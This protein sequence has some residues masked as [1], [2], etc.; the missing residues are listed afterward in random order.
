[1]TKEEINK[2]LTKAM[3]IETQKTQY[4]IVDGYGG[5]GYNC[6]SDTRAEAQRKL[7]D[8]GAYAEIVKVV[9]NAP[10]YDF[11]TPD[12]FFKL[13][14]WVKQQE[15]WP[16]YLAKYEGGQYGSTVFITTRSIHL[17]RFATQI[18]TFLKEK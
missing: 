5:V 18:C 1:M 4:Q 11:F 15:W 9:G 7:Q 8:F 12:G 17:E 2:F 10:I 16:D 6:F 13:W 3:G 14:R